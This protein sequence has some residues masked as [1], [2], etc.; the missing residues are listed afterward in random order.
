MKRREFIG[1]GTGILAL[2]AM[3]AMLNAKDYRKEMPDVWKVKNDTSSKGASLHGIDAAVKDLFGKEVAADG[4]VNLKAPEIAENGAVVP[5][6]IKADGASRI[7]L[8]ES[9]NPE[10]LVAVFDVPKDAIAEYSVRIKMQ[11][12][13][14]VSAVAEIDGKLHRTD[15]VVKVTVGGC[16]G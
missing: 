10:S 9:A 7:A 11:Q 13:G 8:F 16:G 6:T 12:T 15:K 3:P 14:T 2:A 1:Y 4:K 5:I